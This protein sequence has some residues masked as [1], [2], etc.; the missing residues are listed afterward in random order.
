MGGG[1][2]QE[3]LHRLDAK[4]TDDEDDADDE[5]EKGED[6]EDAAEAFPAFFLGIEEDWMVLIAHAGSLM[7]TVFRLEVIVLR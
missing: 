2:E 4:Q 5:A 3:L 7:G 6:I 1:G